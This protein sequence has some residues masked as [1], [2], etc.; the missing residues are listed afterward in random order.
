MLPVRAFGFSSKA[1]PVPCVLKRLEWMVA[2]ASQLG[3]AVNRTSVACNRDR[4]RVLNG[5]RREIRSLTGETE[6]FEDPL[7]RLDRR[8]AQALAGHVPLGA[9]AFDTQMSGGLPWR[10]L[11]E[12]HAP[13]A[14]DMGTLSGFVAALFARNDAIGACESSSHSEGQAPVLWVIQ[15]H[16]LGETGL[17]HGHGLA[18]M[19]FDPARLRLVVP[20]KLDDALWVCEEAAA[21]PGLAGV[22]LDIRTPKSGPGLR[23]TRR[24][25]MRAMQSRVPL[26][27]L[28]QGGGAY[29]SAAPVRLTVEPAPSRNPVLFAASP[30]ETE[31]PGGIGP[32]GFAVTIAKNKAGPAGNTHILHWNS[33]ERVFFT[34]DTARQSAGEPGRN[35]DIRANANAGAAIAITAQGSPTGNA[36]HIPAFALSG[37]GSHDAPTPRRRVAGQG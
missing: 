16:V 8:R 1:V 22:V 29:A 33:H 11:T 37:D 20:T 25:H 15:S 6:G 32:P 24:L 31:C 9:D 23:E 34:A 4:K 3:V 36:H 2:M 30:M 5:L 27:L 13:A 14:R 10:G 21:T 28:R 12:M 7:A 35:Q 17:P 26:F 18:A 19:G